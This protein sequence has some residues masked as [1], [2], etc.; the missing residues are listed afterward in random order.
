MRSSNYP[1]NSLTVYHKSVPLLISNY[2]VS[3]EFKKPFF[4]FIRDRSLGIREFDGQRHRICAQARTRFL[5]KGVP[6]FTSADR[7][8]KAVKE[9]NKYCQ[10]KGL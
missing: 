4:A 3:K 8:A 9:Y 7:A 10:S 2:K 6:F 5:E 1:K